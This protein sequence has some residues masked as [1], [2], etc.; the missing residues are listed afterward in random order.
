MKSKVELSAML[1]ALEASIP[2]L[3]AQH[4]DDSAFWPAFAG[5]A[6]AIEETAA[7]E[8]YEFVRSRLDCILGSHGLIPSDNQGEDCSPE[9][10]S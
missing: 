7:A 6:D 5:E 1:E 10:T 2:T 3:L 8:D 9:G 4:P